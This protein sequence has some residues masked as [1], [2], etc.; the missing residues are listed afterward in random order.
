MSQS[1]D[2]PGP[3]QPKVL[4]SHAAVKRTMLLACQADQIYTQAGRHARPV[5]KAF[6]VVSAAF[7]SAATPRR[8]DARARYLYSG[9]SV[10]GDAARDHD[11]SCASAPCNLPRSALA[12]SPRRLQSLLSA[13]VE[14]A[15]EM[16][17]MS[18]HEEN[19]FRDAY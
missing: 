1:K 13:A 2:G 8:R 18:Q 12:L 7:G 4:V 14:S 6:T 17:Q 5:R 16:R 10:G 15:M 9:M 19:A 3:E 11:H